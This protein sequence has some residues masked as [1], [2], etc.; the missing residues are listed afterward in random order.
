MAK[1]WTFQKLDDVRKLSEAEAPWYVGW[2]EPDGRRRNASCGAGSQGKKLAE[3]KKNKLIAE[4]MTGT[5]E[6]K[7]NVLWDDFVKEYARRI[8]DGNR[9]SSKRK[10]LESL[11]HYKRLMKP[12][13]LFVICTGHIDEFIAKR[14]KEPGIK[15]GSLV[16]PATVNRDLGHIKAALNAAVE[17]GYLKQTPRFRREKTPK[18]LVRFVTADHFAAIYAACD[19]ARLPRGLSSPAADWWRGLIVLAYMTGWRIGDLLALR[20]DDLDLTTGHAI[21]RAVDNKGGRDDR[22]KLHPVVVEHLARLASFDPLVFPSVHDVVTIR[23][24]YH[25]IQR[26][27]GIHLSCPGRHEHSPRCHVY[28]FHDLRRAFATVN[29]PRLTADALQ[30]LMRHKSYL[31]TQVY[32]NMAKQIDDAVDVLHVPEFLKGKK[33]A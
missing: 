3:R 8:L 30:S 11:G 9:A 5:Y 13:K 26:L 27:A 14:R 29:A 15:K 32:I 19:Q 25:R 18:K 28:G 20:R 17:W 2:L 22:V 10:C 33:N 4:L 24:E 1:A 6:T 23:E 12:L 7:T 31:T 21:T 16:S